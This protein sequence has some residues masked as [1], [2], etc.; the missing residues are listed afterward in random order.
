M[1]MKNTPVTVTVEG[2][3]INVGCSVK[4][5]RKD[6]ATGAFIGCEASCSVTT[7]CDEKS[8]ETVRTANA[9]FV[10]VSVLAQ[11]DRTVREVQKLVEG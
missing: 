6:E 4:I 11:L 7:P 10:R 3:K 8:M 5:T 1:N 9:K 2:G